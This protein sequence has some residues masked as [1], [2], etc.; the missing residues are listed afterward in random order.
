MIEKFYDQIRFLLTTKSLDL[1]ITT[2]KSSVSIKNGI[3]TAIKDGSNVFHFPEI[4]S[5]YRD[6][7]LLA[8]DKEQLSERWII[9]SHLQKSRKKYL[10]KIH[11]NSVSEIIKKLQ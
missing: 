3:I 6:N 2:D 5:Q 8:F 7:E 4:S 11:K 10:D 1:E 9:Y